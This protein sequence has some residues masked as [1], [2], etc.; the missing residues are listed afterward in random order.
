M[1]RYPEASAG[2]NDIIYWS[3][4]KLGP[5][6]VVSV[7]HLAVTRLAAVSAGAIRGGITPDLWFTLL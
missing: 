6:V 3:K 7:T 4:E 5:E 2:T 1:R